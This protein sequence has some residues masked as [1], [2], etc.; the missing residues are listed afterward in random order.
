[1]RK[2]SRTDKDKAQAHISESGIR[3]KEELYKAGLWEVTFYHSCND[4]FQITS[5]PDTSPPPLD[6]ERPVLLLLNRR[7]C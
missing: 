1:M 7:A 4:F 5:E 2:L 3:M 6:G